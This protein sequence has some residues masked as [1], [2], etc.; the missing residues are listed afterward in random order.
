MRTQLK[1]FNSLDIEH[2]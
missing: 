2:F 1:C